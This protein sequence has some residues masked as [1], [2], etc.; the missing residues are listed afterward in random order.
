[1]T[2]SHAWDC[3]AAKAA[4]FEVAYTTT[5]E[6]D[7]CADVFGKFDLVVPDLISLANGVVEKWGKK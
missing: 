7:E 3:A 2:A 5:Y 1:M 4:G 6:W